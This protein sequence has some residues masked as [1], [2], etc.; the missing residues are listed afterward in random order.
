M[1]KSYVSP[2]IEVFDLSG[3]LFTGNDSSIITP[4]DPLEGN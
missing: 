2:E 1:K 3:T 4:V